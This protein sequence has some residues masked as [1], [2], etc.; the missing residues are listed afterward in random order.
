MV[1]SVRSDWMVY[2]CGGGVRRGGEGGAGLLWS[3]V[4]W[5]TKGK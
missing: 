3:F 5:V 4:E 2:V 1:G